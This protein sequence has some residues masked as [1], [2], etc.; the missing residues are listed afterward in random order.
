LAQKYPEPEALRFAAA[1]V[2]KDIEREQYAPKKGK[3][4]P[5]ECLDYVESIAEYL[6]EHGLWNIKKISQWGNPL[7]DMYE[8]EHILASKTNGD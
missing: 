3:D 4:I 5:S 1:E 6:K 8:F 7:T 2:R